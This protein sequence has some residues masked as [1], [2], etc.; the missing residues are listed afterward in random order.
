LFADGPLK[1][2]LAEA[3][4]E[5]HILP[6]APGIAQMRKDT[7]GGKTLLRLKDV[8]GILMYIGR[9]A[10][11][12]RAQRI[13]LVHTNSLKADVIGGFAARLA[14]I[15]VLWHVRDRIETDYLPGSAVSTFRWLCRRVPDYVVTNSQ[16]TLETLKMGANG[17]SAAIPSGTRF[18]Q[19]RRR[20]QERIQ[21]TREALTDAAGT[22]WLPRVGLIGRIAPWKGQ[23]VF[24][25]AATLVRQRFPAARFQIIGAALFD[26]ARYEAEIKALT[27]SL[28][29]AEQV[30]FT[31]FRDDVTELILELD[32]LV[33][34][35]TVAEPFGQVILEG[36]AA[37]KPVVATRGGGVPEIVE[38]GVT[39]LLVPMG[40]VEAMADAICTV[41]ADPAAAQRMGQQGYQRVCDHFTIEQTARKVEGV[42]EQI[43]SP[44]R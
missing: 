16:A 17:R 14:G 19:M 42:Y 13:D 25:Q 5:T 12:M 30:E 20:V 27:L 40:D 43:L 38:E 34:A 4:V 44:T 2:K 36:M 29:L 41:L 35:S 18:H 8:A 1:A 23:H 7:L 24:L 28:G 9:L 31:G 26:E 39:G 11:F 22:E 15:P 21:Y 6:L 32:L 33:H 37:G 3:S 10:R